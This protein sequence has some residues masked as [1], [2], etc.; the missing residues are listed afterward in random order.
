MVNMKKSLFALSLLVFISSCD[1]VYIEEVNVDDRDF[2]TG[3]YEVEEYSETVD[4][5]TFYNM[6][7]LKEND[8]RSNVIFL[9]N[10]YAVG[11]EI[12]AEVYGDELRIPR[13]II[14]GYRVQGVGHVDR[15][16]LVM[17]YSV[18][19]LRGNRGFADFCNTIAY[20]R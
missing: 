20:R 5:T 10:F 18:E 7:V 19:D 16:D 13:Q 8:V 9:D 15:G 6:R 12:F 1:I 3:R 11:I 2:F 14:N 4:Q 17:T